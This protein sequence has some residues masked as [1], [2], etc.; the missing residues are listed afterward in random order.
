MY[1]IYKASKNSV[2]PRTDPCGTLDMTAQD[3]VISIIISY[4][5][6]GEGTH[7]GNIIQVFC[8]EK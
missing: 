6:I 7:I 2:G 8:G 4:R 3:N 5:R 1:I